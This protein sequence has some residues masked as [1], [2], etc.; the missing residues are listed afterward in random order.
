MHP[1]TCMGCKPTNIYFFNC[2]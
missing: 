1:C 2:L